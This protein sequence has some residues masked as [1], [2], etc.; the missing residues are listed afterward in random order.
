MEGDVATVGITEH[1]QVALGDI[2]F[3]DL[4]EK[5]SEAVSGER[6]ATVESVKAA[7]D[8]YSPFNGEIVGVN[9]RLE[10]APDLINSEPHGDGWIFQVKLSDPG[11]MEPLMSAEEYE[12]SLE[13][14]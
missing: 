13:D 6:A 5:G 3:A 10:E 7:A 14:E 1:A 4:P 12:K 2:V 8:I 11:E 9:E